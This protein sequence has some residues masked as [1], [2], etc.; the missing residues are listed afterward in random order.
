MVT[1]RVPVGT[2]LLRQFG[3]G[4]RSSTI[5]ERLQNG[6]IGKDAAVEGPFGSKPLL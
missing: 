5:I 2:G 4:I 3:D 1:N 6:L